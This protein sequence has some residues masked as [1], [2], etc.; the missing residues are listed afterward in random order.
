M[1]KGNNGDI[2]SVLSL[3]SAV[4]NSA[5]LGSMIWNNLFRAIFSQQKDIPRTVTICGICAFR[6]FRSLY[7][8]SF[9]LTTFPGF[10]LGLI[11][12]ITIQPF[13]NFPACHFPLAYP[14]AA[15]GIDQCQQLIEFFVFACRLRDRFVQR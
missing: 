15:N 13:F 2:R 10:F 11:F 14:A 5:T 7:F 6:M 3:V 9:L 12:G 8:P 4:Y 1:L